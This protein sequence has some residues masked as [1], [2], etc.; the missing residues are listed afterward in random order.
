M[1]PLYERHHE[2]LTITTIIKSFEATYE[3]VHHAKPECEY[4]SGNWFLVNGQKRDRRWLL[5]EIECLR[6]SLIATAVGNMPS[7]KGEKRR[8]VSQVLRLLSRMG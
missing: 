2:S 7:Y 3:A 5:L 4:L 1:L 8:A 6:Q